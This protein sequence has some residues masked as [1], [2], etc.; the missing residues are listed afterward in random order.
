MQGVHARVQGVSKGLNLPLSDSRC[1]T[2]KYSCDILA[3]GHT[4]ILQF[5]ICNLQFAM[6]AAEGRAS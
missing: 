5:P 6:A 2:M 1:D 3:S 4:T